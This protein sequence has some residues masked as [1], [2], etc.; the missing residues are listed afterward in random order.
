MRQALR[1]NMPL[2]EVLDAAVPLRQRAMQW[3]AKAESAAPIGT[4]RLIDALA[5]AADRELV[6]S[7]SHDDYRSVVGGVQ[8]CIG[9]EQKEFNAAGWRYLHLSPATPLPMLADAREPAGFRFLAVLDG[10]E[11]GVLPAEALLTA[12]E[13]YQA[14]S[15]SSV[16]LVVHTLLGNS[17]EIIREIA[18]AARLAAGQAVFWIHDF[19]SIC[20]NFP[21]LRNDVAFCGAP[22][23]DS[24]ACAICIYGEDRQGQSGRVR[25]FLGDL[26]PQVVAPSHAALSFWCSRMDHARDQGRV[27]PHAR[28]E[29]TADLDR[30]VPDGRRLRAA[31]LGVPAPHKGWQAF[32]TLVSRVRAS[33]L[34]GAYE[35]L[36]LGAPEVAVPGL[37]HV[38]TI[39]T[40]S[41]P[42]A[43]IEALRREGVD[44][45]VNWSMC[46]E[47]FSFAAHEAVAAGAWLVA[48]RDSGAIAALVE[49]LGQGTL[50]ESDGE[51]LEMFLSGRIVE[52]VSTA[53]DRMIPTWQLVHGGITAELLVP[54]LAAQVA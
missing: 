16:F 54:K 8:A 7:I 3:A 5:P 37:R 13:K 28:L 39:A 40:P 22:S 35:F 2:R 23:V 11:I 41:R 29:P 1:A 42:D 31:F 14:A 19:S 43:M 47:T 17:P 4:G 36:H 32:V 45:V 15:R 24:P 53:R 27:L 34:A 48:R 52:T 51:L 50:L 46:F 21:L 30:P 20:P 18:R 12:L 44:V 6:L 9:R 49:R 25:R 10:R 26:R 38:R 33:D